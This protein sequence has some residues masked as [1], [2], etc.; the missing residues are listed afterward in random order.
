MA[1]VD[2]IYILD[3][4]IAQVSDGAIYSPGINVG[5]PMT[6]SCNAYLVNHRGE[7]L[8]WDTGIEDELSKYPQGRIIA[9]GIRGIVRRPI[10]DQ[11]DEIGVRP[12]DISTILLSCA[13]RSYRECRSVRKCK[14]DRSAG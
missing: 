7:W 13:F 1:T 5:V 2:R 6:L 14:M 11:L 10:A 3:G 8:I 9:H 12:R 4:G